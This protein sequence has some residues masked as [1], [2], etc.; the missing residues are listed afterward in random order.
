LQVIPISTLPAEGDNKFGVFFFFVCQKG[1]E[2]SHFFFFVKKVPVVHICLE[3]QKGDGY[4]HFWNLIFP[5]NKNKT[6]ESSG[7]AIFPRGL[8][9][10][11]SSIIIP[12]YFEEKLNSNQNLLQ[13]KL[14]FVFRQQNLSQQP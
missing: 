13:R 1:A 14:F 9:G 3:F 8:V 6:K 7:E 11:Y 12:P 4:I 2:K 5:K 10:Y